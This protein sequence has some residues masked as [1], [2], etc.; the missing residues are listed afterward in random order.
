MFN[1]VK[2]IKIICLLF[3]IFCIFN[4]CAFGEE[5]LILFD[6]SVSMLE[7][8]NGTP[9]YLQATRAAKNVLQNIP[10]DKKIGLRIIG[11]KP[12]EYIFQY[13]LSPEKLCSATE[14]LNPISTNNI[15]NISSSLDTIIPLGVTPL[16]YSLSLAIN[17]DFSNNNELKHIILI[18]DG[19][20]SCNENPCNY[21]QQIMN[22]RDDIKIDVI[23]FTSNN[24][25]LSQLEC[26]TSTTKGKMIQVNSETDFS[27]AFEN[28]INTMPLQQISIIKDDK[29]LKEFQPM[30][31]KKY[32]DN[33][34]KYKNY[35]FEFN[36]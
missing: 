1:M 13:L 29:N 21:I 17:N 32:Y 11:I 33:T 18:T 5:T 10:P 15:E 24:D 31:Q 30:P 8:L 35:F 16:K 27:I 19:A 36:K 2:Y 20:E 12:D 14:L 28:I 26:L 6:S 9:K 22:T 25:E 23:S 7:N 3:G 34:I 4:N